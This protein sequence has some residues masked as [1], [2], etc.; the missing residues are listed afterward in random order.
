M[1]QDED[2]YDDTGP[3]SYVVLLY[4]TCGVVH[5]VARY[6]ATRSSSIFISFAAVFLLLSL[7]IQ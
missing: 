5:V 4:G 7:S 1:N 3:G 2:S 6:W